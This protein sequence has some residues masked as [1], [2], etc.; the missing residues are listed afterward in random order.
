MNI[1]SEVDFS[2]TEVMDFLAEQESQEIR[3]VDYWKQALLQRLETPIE[4]SGITLPWPKTHP[5]VRLR[6]GE[7][8]LWAGING[9]FKSSIANQVALYATDFAKVG[10]MSF[11]MPA[12]VTLE[13]MTKQACGSGRPPAEY[14]SDLLDHLSDRMW[15]YDHLDSVD[16]ERALACVHHMAKIGIKLVVLDC[17]IMVRGI[18]RDTERESAFMST[19]TAL[20]KGHDIHIALVHHVRKPATGGDEYIPTRFDIR[21]ASDIGDMASSIFILHNNKRKAEAIRK[22]EVGASLSDTEAKELE[23]P[24]QLFIVAKQ[25]NAPFEGTIGLNLNRDAMQFRESDRQRLH[26]DIAR[27]A[28]A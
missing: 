6:G 9:H 10:I 14:A 7:V 17:L 19:L 13:R 1:I 15:I 22:R 5:N 4:A 16:P 11:E 3:S 12:E 25:R 28:A 27:R 24:C 21:G 26:L 23:R 8:S 2:D 20:A 18:T